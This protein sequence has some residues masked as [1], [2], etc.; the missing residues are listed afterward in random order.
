M[1]YLALTFFALVFFGVVT[2]GAKSEVEIR[3]FLASIV[4][5]IGFC[6]CVLFTVFFL[7]SGLINLIELGRVWHGLD[8]LLIMLAGPVSYLGVEFVAKKTLGERSPG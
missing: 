7:F 3:A 2:R 1:N 5:G 4:W 6:A 8:C